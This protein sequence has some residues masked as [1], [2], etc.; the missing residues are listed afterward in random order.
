VHLRISSQVQAIDSYRQYSIGKGSAAARSEGTG[1]AQRVGSGAY[2]TT[3]LFIS[4]RVRTNSGGLTE[5]SKRVQESIS[6]MQSAEVSLQKADATLNNMRELAVISA[7]IATPDAD[8]IVLDYE[9]TR[10]KF[11]LSRNCTLSFSGVDHTK[12]DTSA[13][14]SAATNSDVIGNISSVDSAVSAISAI[15][16]ALDEIASSRVKL[17]DAQIELLSGNQGS[18]SS[19]GM[20]QHS[21]SRI[22]D[23]G[24]AVKMAEQIQ[25]QM[26]NAPAHSILAHANALPQAVLQ[27]LS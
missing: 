23:A 15:G 25:S 13:L 5:A 20:Q 7:D 21:V 4:G 2:D 10:F 26:M 8:R 14:I 22:R 19:V 16:D 1:S 17:G 12:S 27:L 6:Q 24:A 9:F 18:G 11:E 3:A